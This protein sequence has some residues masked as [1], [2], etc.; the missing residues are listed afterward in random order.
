MKAECQIMLSHCGA[1]EDSFK[2]PLDCKET[3]P[4]H[5]KGDQSWMFTRWTDARAEPLILWPP[6]AKSLLIG[7]DPNVEKD[8]RWE[9]KGWQR[10]RWLDGV[11]DST[12]T[13]LSKPQE[14]VKDWGTWCTAVHDVAKSR[15][16]LGGWKTTAKTSVSLTGALGNPDSSLKRYQSV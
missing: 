4:V 8:W 5:P 15:T 3:Q 2:S 16:W 12:D 14:I 1:G 13:S 6:D 10:T 9:E 11:T 7:K